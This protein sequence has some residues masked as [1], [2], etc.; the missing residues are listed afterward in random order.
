MVGTYDL[1]F[2]RTLQNAIDDW[3]SCPVNRP[4]FN[5]S[6]PIICAH[7]DSRYL[8][9]TL[10]RALRYM[11]NREHPEAN[12]TLSPDE[13]LFAL[14]AD[15]PVQ[16]WSIGKHPAYRLPWVVFTPDGAELCLKN[17]KL[18]PLVWDP[19]FPPSVRLSLG[20]PRVA[21]ATSETED[22]QGTAAPG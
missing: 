17:G 5:V 3:K 22:A 16:L 13:R 11:L 15:T 21:P 20:L 10:H 19:R 14:L 7:P 1:V 18:A 4:W 6:P 12:N 8:C 2:R 9:V